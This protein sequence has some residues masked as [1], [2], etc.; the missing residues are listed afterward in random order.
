MIWPNYRPA[1]T[2][3]KRPKTLAEAIQGSQRSKE[4]RAKRSAKRREMGMGP[5]RTT[6]RAQLDHLWSL[7]I[8]RRDR[9]ANAGYCLICRVRPIQ[10]AY[11]IVPRADD[12]T[13]WDLENGVGACCECNYA[14]QMNRLKYRYKHIEI[15]GEKKIDMLE[16][17]S[18]GM[19]KFSLADLI[20]MRD[21][22]KAKL[23]G[24]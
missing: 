21:A 5:T 17:K 7:V 18:R 11:H 6:V 10:V 2:G 20:S 8:R 13:R 3:P 4:R 15:F 22:L 24:R 16:K 1:Q 12:T 14:E 23:E 9:I 19:A